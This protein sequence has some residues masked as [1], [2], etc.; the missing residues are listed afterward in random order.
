MRPDLE[1][2]PG[3]L[4]HVGRS[5]DGQLVDFRRQRDRSQDARAGPLRRRHDLRGRLVQD[6]MV[7]RLQ[8]DA[9]LFVQ[10]GPA[11][12]PLFGR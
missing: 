8:A 11:S 5:I 6:A 3:L 9:N 2:L 10:H 12:R 4:V 7:I 1:L